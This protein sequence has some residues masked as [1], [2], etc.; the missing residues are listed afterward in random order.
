MRRL[1]PGLPGGKE[2]TKSIMTLP[3][4]CRKER[5]GGAAHMYLMI[6]FN[7]YP[8]TNTA[9]IKGIIYTLLKSTNRMDRSEKR[10]PWCFHFYRLAT[11]KAGR[12]SGPLGVLPGDY[13]KKGR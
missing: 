13:S 7:L 11:E 5:F 10:L 2:R 4:T 9:K 3:V 6:L 1:P 12:K 8:T